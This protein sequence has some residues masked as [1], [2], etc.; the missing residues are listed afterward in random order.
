MR[1]RIDILL[2][3]EHQQVALSDNPDQHVVGVYNRQAGKLVVMHLLHDGLDAV[4]GP[5]TLWVG[6]HNLADCCAHSENLTVSSMREAG[7][8]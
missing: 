5:N 7:R 1:W 4:L 3:V 6:V 2:L 8:Q